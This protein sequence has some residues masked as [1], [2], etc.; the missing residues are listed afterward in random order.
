VQKKR[1]IRGVTARARIIDR[2][3]RYLISIGGIGIIAAVLG[4]LLFILFEAYPL[5]RSPD[6]QKAAA[7]MARPALVIGMDPY[8]AIAYIASAEG[9][10]FMR[11][12]DGQIEKRERPAALVGGRAVSAA[13][14]LRDGVLAWGLDDGRVLLSRI[15]FRLDYSSGERLVQPQFSE[16]DLLVLDARGEAINTLAFQDEGEGRAAVAGISASGRVLLTLR[17]EQ[18]GLLGPGELV[19]VSYDLTADIEAQPKSLLLDRRLRRLLVGMENGHIG[20]W[21]LADADARPQYQGSFAASTAAI[22]ALEHILGDVSIIVGDA[23][24]RL[25]TWAKVEAGGRRSF[26]RKHAL[27]SHGAA[28]EKLVSSLRD[29]QF[30]SAD[31]S[32]HIALHH[33]TTEQT[34]FDIIGDG[35]IADLVIAPKSDGFVYIAQNGQL[36]HYQIDNPHPEITLGVLFGKVWYEGYHEAEFVWQSTGGTDEFEPKLSLIP[37]LFGTVKG[38]FYALLFALPLAVMA[39]IYT[40]EFA[41]PRVRGIVKPTVEVMAS[42]PSVILGFLAGLWLAPLLETRLVGTL[43]LLPLVPV[44]AVLGSWCWQ[45]LPADLVRRATAR[46][47]IYLLMGV[48]LLSTWLAFVLGPSFEKMVFAGHFLSWLRDDMGM[49]YDQRNSLV[50]GFAMGFAVVPLI[51]TICEDSLSSIPSHL[52]AGSLALGATRWQT[53]VR[54]VLPMAL[55]GI[56]SASMIGF[57]RAIGE[58][59]IVLMATGNTPVMD[60][61]IFNGMRTISAN[62]AVELPEAPHQGTLYRV[63]FLSGLLLFMATFA[64]NTLAEIVRQRL[65]DRYSRL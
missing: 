22:T 45:Q 56:F 40:A 14:S 55:P 18:R 46:W 52:R 29:K 4:I 30:L 37:L 7:H 23:E 54:V 43:L 21:K 47:E 3:G 63:L 57:G 36:T 58:T 60:W 28:V 8:H 24:G 61:N 15:Q 62:I 27:R 34:F 44:V 53:A 20:E 6:L 13:R 16:G 49:A 11:L 51:F 32:G 10:D 39:A 48:T 50:V 59:M 12:E 33:M 35:R 38:T 2:V 9:V 41:S 25:H 64:I 65:R 42:L 1:T 31:A 17:E 26:V 19:E 5:F